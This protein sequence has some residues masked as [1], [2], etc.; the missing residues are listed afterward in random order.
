MKNTACH[1]TSP[2]LKNALT[3]KQSN[4]FLKVLLANKVA[5][6]V[7]LDRAA[8][9]PVAEI[10]LAHADLSRISAARGDTVLA[11]RESTAAL[12]ALARIQGIYDVRMQPRLWLV[13]SVALL[14]S[15][16]AAAAREWAVKALQASLVYD[17][18]ESPA[19]ADA[20]NA[21][22]L[23]DAAANGR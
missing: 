22:R 17:S 4:R 20:R 19:I 7:V 18:S 6:R 15:S 2:E 12:A 16:N 9:Q 11:L 1:C 13:H 23:A 21:I 14:K 5:L 8:D 3:A 10:S